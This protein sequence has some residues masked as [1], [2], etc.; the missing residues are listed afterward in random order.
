MNRPEATK[1]E[2][3]KR[4]RGWVAPCVCRVCGG[5]TGPV[6][7]IRPDGVRVVICAR[8]HVTPAT[9]VERLRELV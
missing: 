8:G 4:E 2:T 5:V 6:L 9:Q 1:V 7:L 3:A